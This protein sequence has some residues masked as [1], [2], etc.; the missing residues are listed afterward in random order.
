MAVAILSHPVADFAKWKV[1]YDGDQERRAG[2]GLKE[3]HVGQD[4]KDP[5]M[6][7][8]IYE[9]KDPGVLQQ[10]LSDP[11]LAETMKQAGVTGPP[12]IVIIQ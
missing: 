3:I 6:V 7:Y 2:A 9:T 8:M 4:S 12:E 10:M 11:N 1:V 5:N